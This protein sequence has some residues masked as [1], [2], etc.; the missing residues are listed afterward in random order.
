MYKL[1]IITLTDDLD[2]FCTFY[3]P[4]NFDQDKSRNLESVSKK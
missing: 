1:Q 4:I 2:I 3:F